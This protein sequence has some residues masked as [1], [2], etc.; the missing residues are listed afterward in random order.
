MKNYL[1]LLSTI[2]IIVLTSFAI[3]KTTP[4]KATTPKKEKE[5]CGTCT[6]PSSLSASKSYNVIT[7]TWMSTSNACNVAG[8]YNYDSAGQGW[9]KRFQLLNV[10]S[11]ASLY[12]VNPNA[13]SVVFSVTHIC[14]DG[15]F[16]QSGSTLVNL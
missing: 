12:Q 15:T 2:L 13:Y 7:F 5:I 1:Y 11:P 9:S 16:S 10:Y 4:K 6:T 14:G 8:Y 3:I